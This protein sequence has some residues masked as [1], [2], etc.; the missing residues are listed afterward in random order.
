MEN[1]NLPT[2][3][4]ETLVLSGFTT[5]KDRVEVILPYPFLRV[6][7]DYINSKC[8]WSDSGTVSEQDSLGLD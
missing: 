5:N 4:V 7:G 6:K 2:G 3:A 1:K 8:E